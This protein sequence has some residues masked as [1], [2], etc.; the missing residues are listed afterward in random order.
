M[1]FVGSKRLFVALVISFSLVMVTMYVG[2]VHD[3]SRNAVIFSR[4]LA[5]PLSAANLVL[6]V[7]YLR[8]GR[9]TR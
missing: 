4:V 5:L 3:A 9:S 1:V 6:L 7:A 8:S 2:Y